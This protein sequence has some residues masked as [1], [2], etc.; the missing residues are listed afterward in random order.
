M[1]PWLL[2]ASVLGLRRPLETIG[3]NPEGLVWPGWL[4]TGPS[5]DR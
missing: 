4:R 1:A 2:F 5:S 3:L